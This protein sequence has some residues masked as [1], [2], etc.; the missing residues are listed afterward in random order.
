MCQE[1][2]AGAIEPTHHKYPEAYVLHYMDFLISHPSESTH[3][4]ILADLTKDLE[5][6]RLCIAPEKVQKNATFSKFRASYRQI[7]DT[8]SKN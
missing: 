5:V 7:V 8:S 6:W 1:F 2:V 3:L 4:L